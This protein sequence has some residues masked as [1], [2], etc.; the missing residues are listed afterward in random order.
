MRVPV[1]A[2]EVVRRLPGL[3]GEGAVAEVRNG[4]EGRG[5]SVGGGHGPQAGL[6]L[7]LSLKLV[8]L[9]HGQAGQGQRDDGRGLHLRG[10]GQREAGGAAGQPRDSGL[11]GLP[12]AALWAVR[13][14]FVQ[15]V[16]R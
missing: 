10:D 12:S 3:L 8:V 1:H 4:V 2:V 7:E 6:S 13:D 9:V 5:L 11:Q 15:L 14:Q 16:C